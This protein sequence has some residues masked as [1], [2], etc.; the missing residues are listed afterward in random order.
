[1]TDAELHVFGSLFQCSSELLR[2]CRGVEESWLIK[3]HVLIGPCSHCWG[4]LQGA[5]ARFHLGSSR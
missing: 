4:D 3:R 1:M 2:N 5:L